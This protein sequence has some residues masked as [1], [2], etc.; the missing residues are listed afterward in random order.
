MTEKQSASVLLL[1]EYYGQE[2][3]VEVSLE[4]WI[5]NHLIALEGK[6]ILDRISEVNKSM[7]I[8]QERLYRVI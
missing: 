5:R 1:K 2:S 8:R 7:K 6:T 3:S 4:R